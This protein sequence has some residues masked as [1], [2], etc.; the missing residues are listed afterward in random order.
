[1]EMDEYENSVKSMASNSENVGIVISSSDTTIAIKEGDMVEGIYCG[2]SCRKSMPGC[3]VDAKL[4]AVDVILVCSC[5]LVV[6][7]EYLAM[8]TWA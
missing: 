5:S 4:E 3:V 1:M 2:R 6:T 7:V 8:D